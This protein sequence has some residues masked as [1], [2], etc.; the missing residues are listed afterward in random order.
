MPITANI[1][2]LKGPDRIRLSKK[3]GEAADGSNQMMRVMVD[4]RSH[5]VAS[6]ARGGCSS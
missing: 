6:V 2:G 1:S 3:V 5:Q 4:A